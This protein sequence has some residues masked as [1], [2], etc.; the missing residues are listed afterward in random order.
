MPRSVRAVSSIS[1][2][3]R[4]ASPISVE[5]PP[6]ATSAQPTTVPAFTAPGSQVTV[7]VLTL[8][9]GVSGDANVLKLDD[10][11]LSCAPQ[12]QLTLT[13]GSNGPW[14]VEIGRAHV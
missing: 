6:V 7:K 5:T 2:R 12:P 1:R 8:K 11:K 3:A 4:I 13:K 9:D 10:L 14:T